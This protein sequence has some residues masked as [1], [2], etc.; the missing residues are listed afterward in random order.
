M[1]NVVPR[2]V[3]VLLLAFACVGM[4]LSPADAAQ[5]PADEQQEEFL[6]LDELPPE[7]R[8]PAAPLLVGAY[9]FVVVALFLYLV[10][11]GRRMA[12]VQREIER[13]DN[14]LKRTGRA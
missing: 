11:L 8:L 3:A 9:V 5:P 1:I 7:E 14:D 4:L 2:T 6:P 13:L 10:S 12:A